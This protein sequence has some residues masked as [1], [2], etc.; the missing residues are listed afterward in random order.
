MENG[1]NR[2]CKRLIQRCSNSTRKAG[3]HW[4]KR[5]RTQ[6]PATTFGLRSRSPK[7]KKAADQT[8]RLHQS[9]PKAKTARKLILNWPL[10]ARRPSKRPQLPGRPKQAL[11]RPRRQR[12][13]PRKK[14][15]M[16]H[17]SVPGPPRR[18]RQRVARSCRA[19][20]DSLHLFHKRENDE[21][22]FRRQG[23]QDHRL[24]RRR[25][26]VSEHNPRC[27]RYVCCTVTD[28]CQSQGIPGN[29]QHI[30]V[31]ARDKEIKPEQEICQAYRSSSRI[32]GTGSHHCWNRAVIVTATG[33]E[34]ADCCEEQESLLDEGNLLNGTSDS[35]DLDQ[36]LADAQQ[37]TREIVASARSDASDAV[38]DIWPEARS[39]SAAQY[40]DLRRAISEQFTGVLEDSSTLWHSFFEPEP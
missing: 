26:S 15:R 13:Q 22:L 8:R 31:A 37:G 3:S 36:C 33:F 12:Q 32:I 18:R 9:P 21:G 24:W 30:K 2:A 40:Q 28:P 11:H 10:H 34:I 25:T 29:S 16:A 5:S 6:T 17:R 4:K 19:P 14:R 39:Y 38:A 20:E 35:F 23:V 1:E 7:K 27:L